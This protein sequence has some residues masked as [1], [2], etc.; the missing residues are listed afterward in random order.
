MS[1]FL[2]TDENPEGHKLESVLSN[3]RNEIF[4]RLTLIMDDGRPEAVAVM[5]NNIKILDHL[6]ESITLAENSSA[7]LDK[8]F[9]QHDPSMPRIGKA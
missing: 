5:N 4:Q 1:R 3:I 8:A 9:G 7:V 2:V 6:A